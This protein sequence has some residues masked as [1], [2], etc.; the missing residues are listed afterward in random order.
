MK[1][2][3]YRQIASQLSL[4]AA[5]RTIFRADTK[6]VTAVAVHPPYVYSVSKDKTLI[7]WELTTPKFASG[8]SD[9]DEKNGTQILRSNRKKPKKL[10]FARG[11]RPSVDSGEPQGHKGSILTVSVSPSGRFVA[12]GGT[13][14]RIVIWDAET[15]TPLKTFTQ[16]RDSV[17]CLSFTR[18]RS[19]Q[20]T[21]E[22][23]FS[24]SFDRTIKT[25]SISPGAH[26]YVETL[27]GHQDHVV[28]VKSMAMDQ[29][30][31]VGARDRTARLWKVVDETQLIFRGGSTKTSYVDG[32]IDCI[33]VIPPT[34]FITGSDSGTISLWSMHKKK[35]LDSIHEAHGLDP[36]PPLS[37]LS[38]EKHPA[39]ARN[40]TR[41][42]KPNARWITAL[43]TLPGT[44]VVFSGSW[45]GWIRTW[46]ISE[47]KRKIIP[48][49][50]LGGPCSASSAIDGMSPADG[51]SNAQARD[52]SLRGIVND[53]AVFERRAQKPAR[54][55]SAQ[56]LGKPSDEH[57]GLCVV[58]ALGKEHRLGRWKTLDS[59]KNKEELTGRNGA[60]VFEV[61]FLPHSG[62]GKNDR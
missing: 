2:R 37:D 32:S 20:T 10:K 46:R 22:Q 42:I 61:P 3:S 36:L 40:N 25:W 16:H 50:R 12:T 15:L 13:D 26:A 43:A 1:G 45:D 58:A 39:T 17:S 34:H 62:Y 41:N 19:S 27:F 18:T 54:S 60:V 11:L 47:D 52:Y 23:L 14:R 28:S 29:C 44:D 51:D 21:G 31:S 35:P 55:D 38:S 49:G 4:N 7:K 6:S 8:V 48:V 24:S 53:I 9:T 56:K 57:Q 59:N 30:V 5:S 33:A